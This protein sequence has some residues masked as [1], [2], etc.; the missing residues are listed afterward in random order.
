VERSRS[1]GQD[2]RRF[3]AVMDLRCAGELGADTGQT[4]FRSESSGEIESDL[5]T[6]YKLGTNASLPGTIG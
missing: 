5:L 2:S 6:V 4:R 1:R 3:G